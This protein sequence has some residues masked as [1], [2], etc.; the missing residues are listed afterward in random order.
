M[1][2]K[3][4]RGSGAPS[5]AKAANDNTNAK[6]RDTPSR[7]RKAPPVTVPTTTAT[8]TST[9]SS[10]SSSNESKGGVSQDDRDPDVVAHKRVRLLRTMD[11]LVDSSTGVESKLDALVQSTQAQMRRMQDQMDLMANEQAIVH[12]KVQAL[13]DLSQTEAKENGSPTEFRQWLQSLPRNSIAGQTRADLEGR[14]GKTV[15]KRMFAKITRELQFAYVAHQGTSRFSLVDR[16]ASASTSTST[17]NTTDSTP[18][19]QAQANG[20]TNAKTSAARDDNNEGGL[21]SGMML[22]DDDDY[23]DG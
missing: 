13:L 16:L 8:P 21:P 9:P 14:W 7:K 10:S 11:E 15:D 1:T 3:T 23:F 6:T 4:N 2:D 19:V 17:N 20:N 12:R 18:K 5:F 22:E